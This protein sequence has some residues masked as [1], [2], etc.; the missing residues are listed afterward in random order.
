MLCRNDAVDVRRRNLVDL[1]KRNNKVE[2]ACIGQDL[3]IL[4]GDLFRRI[5]DDYHKVSVR[6]QRPR[7]FDADALNGI[8]RLTQSGGV[9]Q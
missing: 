1:V 8:A 4:S 6:H 9:D 2:L 5:Q 3:V 7:P